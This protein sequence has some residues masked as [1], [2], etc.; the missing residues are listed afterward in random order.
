MNC[1]VTT[2]TCGLN[3][4]IL[5][6]FILLFTITTKIVFLLIIYQVHVENFTFHLIISFNVSYGPP[7]YETWIKIESNCLVEG[8]MFMIL[9]WIWFVHRH[10]RWRKRK[11]ISLFKFPLLIYFLIFRNRLVSKVKINSETTNSSLRVQLLLTLLKK[12]LK[13]SIC[14]QV[15]RKIKSFTNQTS[16]IFS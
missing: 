6:Y 9:C 12:T 3:K 2:V 8:T 16:S 7:W 14:V 4:L 13:T 5:K 10:W 15:L 1:W 11:T